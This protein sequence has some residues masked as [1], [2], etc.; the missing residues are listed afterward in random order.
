MVMT[1]A[2]MNIG[3]EIML[4][5]VFAKVI[6]THRGLL[7]RDAIFERVR[8]ALPLERSLALGASLLL[9]GLIAFAVALA[10]WSEVGFGHLSRG[11]AIRLVIASSTTLMLGA[12]IVY[13]S[14]FLYLLDYRSERR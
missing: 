14:F 11:N 10:E 3:F 2:A 1:A 4:F 12:Q 5:W 13:G 8:R 6:A 7:L 9:I